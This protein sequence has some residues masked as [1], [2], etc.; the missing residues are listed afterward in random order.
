GE[1]EEA[2]RA[3]GFEW[4]MTSVPAFG[5]DGD[6]YAFT[7]FEQIWIPKQAE[8]KEAAKE[9]ITYMY[10]DEAASTFLEAGAVQHVEGIKDQLEGQKKTFFSIY[11]EQGALPAMGTFASTEP[12]PGVSM[13]DTFF[14]EIDSVMN[15]EMSYEDWQKDVEEASDQLRPAMK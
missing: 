6:R 11:E 8:N 7:F 5:D 15:G 2:P 13:T 10:S 4:G 14:G 1:M 9:F 12:V 3:D